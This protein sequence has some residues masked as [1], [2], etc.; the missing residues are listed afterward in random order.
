MQLQHE[1]E[2]EQ[3]LLQALGMALRSGDP[4]S[5]GIALGNLAALQVARGKPERAIRTVQDGLATLEEAPD[6]QLAGC[7]YLILAR[8]YESQHNLAAAEEAITTAITLLNQTRSYG[9]SVR[10]YEHYAQFLANQG[11]F[12]EAYEQLLLLPCRAQKR[13]IDLP[14]GQI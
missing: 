2:A 10:A 11:R 5:R 12:Q 14:F 13:G 8:A 1:A 3:F 6:R 7:L 9:L 4:F